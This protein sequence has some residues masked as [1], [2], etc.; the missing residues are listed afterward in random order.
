M[1]SERVNQGRYNVAEKRDGAL[2]R[3]TINHIKPYLVTIL[4]PH[5]DSDRHQNLNISNASPLAHAYHVWTTSV[6]VFVSYPA[7]RHTNRQTDRET[8]RQTAVIT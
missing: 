5:P 2:W 6:N 7:H 8:D 1:W 4:D 3:V